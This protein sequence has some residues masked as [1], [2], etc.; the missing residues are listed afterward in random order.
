MHYIYHNG[1]ITFGNLVAFV[2]EI[3]MD[4]RE[5]QR[6]QHEQHEHIHGETIILYRDVTMSST[7]AVFQFFVENNVDPTF[8]CVGI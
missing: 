8:R 2:S 4:E 3:T 7:F 5:T 6:E 1:I